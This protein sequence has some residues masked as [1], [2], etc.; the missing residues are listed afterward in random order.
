MMNSEFLNIVYSIGSYQLILLGVVM[1]FTSGNKFY[2]R[3]LIIFFF[4]KALT[5]INI[6]LWHNVI[7]DFYESYRI[8]RFIGTFLLFVL[9]PLVFLFVKYLI[10]GNNHLYGKD[11]FHFV[12]PFLVIC[13]C[14]PLIF[15]GFRPISLKTLRVFLNTG[16]KIQSIVYLAWGFVYLLRYRQFVKNNFSDNAYDSLRWLEVILIGYSFIVLLDVT[17]FLV[18]KIFNLINLFNALIEIVFLIIVLIWAFKA[19]VFQLK[20]P[21]I[22]DNKQK[23]DYSKLSENE[24]GQILGHIKLF[25][26]NNKPYL[27]PELS[28]KELSELLNINARYISQVINEKCAQN[29]CDFVNSYR[30]N[31][32]IE[33]FSDPKYNNK[34]ISE[35][36]YQC[37]FNSKSAFNSYFKKIVGSTPTEYRKKMLFKYSTN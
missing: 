24:K 12:V 36:F 34:N 30:I 17:N 1:L 10:N 21:D 8:M 6:N 13:I 3:F 19:I 18:Y 15:T 16:F 5:L 25:M 11:I 31:D 2:N 28:L 7:P 33:Y 22:A 20:H 32:C 26:T 29:F 35:V 37:G 14:L 27:N 4:I 9:P 23:Y